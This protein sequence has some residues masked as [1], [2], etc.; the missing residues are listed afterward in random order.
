LQVA[1]Q[2]ITRA[3]AKGIKYIFNRLIHAK[4][5]SRISFKMVKYEVEFKE[6]SS[7]DQYD[8]SKRW[9]CL[10]CTRAW[11]HNFILMVITFN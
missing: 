3:W 5:A 8:L 2:P 6:E 4:Q 9:S 11:L 7:L 10:T 1:I